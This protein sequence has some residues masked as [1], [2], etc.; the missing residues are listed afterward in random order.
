MAKV[1]IDGQDFPMMCGLVTS[2][3]DLQLIGG[4]GIDGQD[5]PVI[6]GLV[7]SYLDL[8]LIGGHSILYIY[9]LFM[10]MYVPT[11]ST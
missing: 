4:Q 10:Y 6:C 9:T 5:F 2:Y 3:L 8:L 7:M 1:C 11:H